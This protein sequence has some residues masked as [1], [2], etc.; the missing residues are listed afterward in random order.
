MRLDRLDHL[1]LTVAD[2]GT[3]VAFYSDVLGMDAVVFE[4]DHHALHFGGSKINLHEAGNE[5]EPKAARPGVGAGDLCFTTTE[6]LDRVQAELAAHG[7]EII[8]GPGPQTGARSRLQSVYLRDPDGNLI[9]IS[10]E[11]SD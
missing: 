5:H 9:E 6:P 8:E 7:V 3:T 11:L 2:I 4:G 10:N 1:V